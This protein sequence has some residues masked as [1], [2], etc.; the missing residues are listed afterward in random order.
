LRHY[1]LTEGAPGHPGSRRRV[2]EV[3]GYFVHQGPPHP[4]S[5]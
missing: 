2:H 1:P 4:P 3:K 5:A